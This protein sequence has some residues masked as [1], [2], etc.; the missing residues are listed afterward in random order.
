MGGGSG[1][2]F[3]C[4]SL[5]THSASLAAASPACSMMQ[6]IDN[7]LNSS[8]DNIVV[9]LVQMVDERVKSVYKSEMRAPT[10]AS[11]RLF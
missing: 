9:Q 2:A 6:S 1:K 11:A 5:W 4:E 7:H 3:Q 10:Q 8:N